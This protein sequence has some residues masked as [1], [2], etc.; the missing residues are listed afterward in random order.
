M[1][2]PVLISIDTLSGLMTRGEDARPLTIDEVKEYQIRFVMRLC[3]GNKT[4][5]CKMLGIDR[6]TLY[7]ILERQSGKPRKSTREVIGA[8]DGAPGA[9][10]E[11][12]TAAS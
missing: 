3:N 11:P 6:R 1:S 10:G 8:D 9:S 7:R 2:E 12:R 5:A 4:T